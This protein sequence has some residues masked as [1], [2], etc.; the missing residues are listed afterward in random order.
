M[1]KLITAVAAGAAFGLALAAPAYADPTPAP[2]PSVT[3]EPVPTTAPPTVGP[4]PTTPAPTTEPTT[5]A[6]TTPA[7]TTPAPTT[8][9]PTTEPTTPPATTPP[10]VPDPCEAYY[11]TGT[12]VS[13]CLVEEFAGPDVTDI[14]CADVVYRVSLVTVGEDPWGL[15]S[16]SA[17]TPGIGCEGNPLAPVNQ[18]PQPGGNGG[19]GDSGDSG[20]LPVTGSSG[21]PNVAL[22]GL[23]L[24]ALGSFG[25]AGTAWYRRRS[26]SFVA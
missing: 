25:V 15:D 12:D 23:G 11:F 10:A 16:D 17:G 13:L 6:P 7:P 1:R 9:A 14:T 22:F 26:T 24:V 2:T 3:V 19:S 18:T 21:I 5:P 8:P 4:T 20:D